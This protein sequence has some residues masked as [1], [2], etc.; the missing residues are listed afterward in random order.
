[1][2]RSL[3]LLGFA[4]LM[5][6]G[7]ATPGAGFEPSFAGSLT[8]GPVLGSKTFMPGGGGWGTVA[9]AE[10]DN[11][12]DPGGNVDAIVWKHWGA[13]AVT[14]T[15]L[16]SVAPTHGT[17]WVSGQKVLLRASNL[18]RCSRSGKMAYRQLR[19]RYPVRPGGP[20]G[21]WE[22]WWH[23]ARDICHRHP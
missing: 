12:G 6:L 1:M 3:V 8:R 7:L 9:P 18:G 23:G 20:L 14:G 2:L 19:V 21:P 15:G 13:S 11:N 16:G 5:G 22:R 10:L 17:G 4:G